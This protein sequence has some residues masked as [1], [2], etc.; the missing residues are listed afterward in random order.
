[1]NKNSSSHLRH[2]RERAEISLRELARQLNIHHTNIVRWEK[3]DRI[4]KADLLPQ[5][6]SILGVS[7]EELLGQPHPKQ[8]IVAPSGKLAQMFEEAARLPR[9]QQQQI[10][11][12]VEPFIRERSKKESAAH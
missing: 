5:L 2:L 1:M 11:E 12:F 4:S 10:I 8:R 6:A 7:V 9:R 3:A